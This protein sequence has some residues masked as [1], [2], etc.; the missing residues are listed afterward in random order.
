VV[1]AFDV[2]GMGSSLLFC[3]TE[4]AWH[5]STVDQAEPAPQEVGGVPAGH[6]EGK[7]GARYGVAASAVPLA[8]TTPPASP[9]AGATGN[10]SANSFGD[11]H[12]RL[13]GPALTPGA[14]MVLGGDMGTLETD[15]RAR[16]DP[17]A[18]YATTYRP[19]G[20]ALAAFDAAVTK[21]SIPATYKDLV[22]D[23]GSRYA[24]P[25]ENPGD[26]ALA[27]QIDLER[28]ALAPAGGT[29]NL[30]IAM[31]SSD[32][33]PGRAPL[34]VHLV[35]DR[36][37]SMSGTAI[38]NARKAAEALVAELEPTDDFSMVTFSNAAELLVGDGPIRPRRHT[39]R[40]STRTR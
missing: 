22:G 35:L 6:D 15:R 2:L 18:R 23:F 38:D 9:Q 30:R 39:R 25:I 24:P 12:G 14:P 27:F 21:G 31:R 32:H 33:M 34:S 16:L 28:E 13:G 19:G 40:R 10:P 3:S 4:R 17:N 11:G 29:V 37:G 5:A 1:A 8:T 20:A 36:S 7:N 26:A